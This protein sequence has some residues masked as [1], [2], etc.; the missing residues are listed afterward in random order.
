MKIC[1]SCN[2]TK[3]LADFY[4]HQDMADGYLN[5]C[6]ECHKAYIK[7]HRTAN[8]EYY[9]AYDRA[10]AALPHRKENAKR[11]IEQWKQDYPERRAAHMKVLYAL[12]SGKLERL[13]CWICGAKAEAHH[14]DYS[15]PLD[16]VWLCP[17]HHKQTHAMVRA[18]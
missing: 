3:S 5:R 7:E 16:V 18:A 4:K 2:E 10:R 11:V 9:R 17:L 6:K 13:P 14:P 1:T 8:A 15:A 12:R